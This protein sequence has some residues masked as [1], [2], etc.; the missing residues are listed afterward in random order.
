MSEERTHGDQ[1][2]VDQHRAAAA[3]APLGYALVTVSDTRTP[4]DDVTGRRMRELV[5]AAGHAVAE[6]AIVRDEVAALRAAAEALLA[7]DGVDVI[8]FAGGTGV[9]PRDVTVEALEPMFER[10]LPGFGELFRLLSHRQIGAAAMLSRA[11]AGVAAGCALFALPGSPKAAELALSELILPE[12]AHLVAQAR[13][14]D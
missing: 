11:T 7:A 1:P 9:A 13:R 5:E 2:S 10:P 12:A 4:D 14:R 8:V 6:Q 3:G